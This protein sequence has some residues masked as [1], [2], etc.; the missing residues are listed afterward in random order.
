ML[1]SLETFQCV[2]STMSSIIG[3]HPDGALSHIGVQRCPLWTLWLH[4]WGCE[5]LFQDPK[6]D[7]F[8]QKLLFWGPLGAPT[9]SKNGLASSTYCILASWTL[10]SCLKPNLVLYKTSRGENNS[11]KGH[12]RSPVNPPWVPLDP[13]RP[14]GAPKTPPWPPIHPISAL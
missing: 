10:M 5:D 6:R 3:N 14:L 2:S 8:A 13:F 11:G 9:W 1:K 7:Q 12:N 4:F